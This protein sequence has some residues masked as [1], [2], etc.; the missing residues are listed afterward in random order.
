MGYKLIKK[1][2]KIFLWIWCWKEIFKKNTNMKKYLSMPFT[3]KWTKQ[4]PIWNCE[5]DNLWNLKL[6][7]LNQFRWIIISAT[8]FQLWLAKKIKNNLQ[9]DIVLNNQLIVLE[10][11]IQFFWHDMY[12]FS[13][14][15][16]ILKII[17][18]CI[19]I[20]IFQNLDIWKL[21]VNYIK[22]QVM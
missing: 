6:S 22:V 4:T 17:N 1:I 9:L 15:F 3:W 16:T 2:F 14:I 10:N 8:V 21:R 7:Y 13:R 19:G 18:L 5:D 11:F 12:L 20:I